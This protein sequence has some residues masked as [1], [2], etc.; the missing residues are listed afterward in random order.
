MGQL[1]AFLLK[2]WIIKKRHPGALF[3]EIVL[4]LVFVG[5]SAVIAGFII[6]VEIGDLPKTI[7]Y[8]PPRPPPSSF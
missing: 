1:K 6:R 5:L 7:E 4:P 3:L 2:S 8:Y